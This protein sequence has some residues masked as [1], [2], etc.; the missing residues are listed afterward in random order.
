VPTALAQSCDVCA[1]CNDTLGCVTN[2]RCETD[3]CF[4]CN[5]ADGGKCTKPR[6]QNCFDDLCVKCDAKTGKCTSPRNATCTANLCFKCDSASGQC[7]P[8]SK[9]EISCTACQVCDSSSG[10]CI[11]AGLCNKCQSCQPN[12]NSYVCEE[13]VRICSACQT[14]DPST[15]DCNAVSCGTCT[16]CNPETNN[17]DVTPSVPCGSNSECNVCNASGE[18]VSKPGQS[19]TLADDDSCR[20]PFCNDAGECVLSVDTEAVGSSCGNSSDFCTSFV[21]SADGSC[22]EQ[23]QPVN[24]SCVLNDVDAVRHMIAK[25]EILFS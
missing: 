4:Q 23:H 17:C 25:E 3:L 15:G 19:C 9:P 14:C 16:A 5:A 1:I 8:I 22:V 18:C 12:A 2:G 7:I 11:D 21:C 10:T 24:T 13:I 20:S 6:D